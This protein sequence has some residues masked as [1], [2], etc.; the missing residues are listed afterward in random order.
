MIPGTPAEKAILE[1]IMTLSGFFTQAAMNET[2]LDR[3]W[4][5]VARS[6]TL[7][8]EAFEQIHTLPLGLEAAL[9]VMFIA[10]FSLAI[11]QMITLFVN[12]VKP[13]RFLLS[14][15]MMAVLYV[16]SNVFWVLST[17][18]M[19]HILFASSAS[20][21]TVLRTLGL[22]YAPLI[23]GFWVALP[24]LGMPIFVLLSLWSLLAVVIGLAIATDLTTWQAFCCSALG[25][26]VLQV[27]HRAIGRPTAAIANWLKNT[28]TAVKVVPN[29]RELEQILQTKLQ[30][31]STAKRT[32]NPT[33]PARG[34]PK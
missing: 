8:R 9:L 4:G 33:A 21:I 20:F 13:I 30:R 16:F 34:K 7:N 19:S 11:G 6:L 3:F 32:L 12:R 29:L 24:Y 25:W 17:G 10:G 5:L 22:A 2:A 1:E 15:L 26:A 31:F 23:G 18:L 14:L 28:A 27:V